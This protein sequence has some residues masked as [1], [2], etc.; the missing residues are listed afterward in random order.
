M[1][2]SIKKKLLFLTDKA[3]RLYSCFQ[4]LLKMMAIDPTAALN[5]SKLH[6]EVMLTYR[7]VNTGKRALSVHL[8]GGSTR[9]QA[10]GSG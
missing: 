3:Y 10:M 6:V 4:V 9:L 7:L 8:E 2:Q 5:N 1:V